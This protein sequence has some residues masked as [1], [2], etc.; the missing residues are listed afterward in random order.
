MWIC[1]L[2][3]SKLSHTRYRE[4]AFRVLVYCEIKDGI[5]NIAAKRGR[6]NAMTVTISV[7]LK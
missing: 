4:S 2:G 5:T 6:T 3:L 1:M 7:H